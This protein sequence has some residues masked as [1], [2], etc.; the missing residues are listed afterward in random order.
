M[1]V[2]SWEETKRVAQYVLLAGAVLA[3]AAGGANALAETLVLSSSDK[4][5]LI[6]LSDENGQAHF[7]VTHRGKALLKPSP[8]GLL[9]DQGVTR[10]RP[11]PSLQQQSASGHAS[12]FEDP[13]FGS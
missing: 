9:L 4:S 13:A 7:A 5:L 12:A 11:S 10:A 6:T 2:M 8:L 3:T 1:T